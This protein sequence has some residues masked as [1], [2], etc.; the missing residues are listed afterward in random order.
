MGIAS[1]VIGIVAAILGFIPYCNFFAIIPAIVG[2]V[3]GIVDVAKKSKLNVPKGM[4]VAGI[5]LN[6][7]AIVIILLWVFII[8]AFTAATLSS[9][10]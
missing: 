3:L 5:V 2:L 9:L 6:S 1:M 8:G 10:Q 4:G 7:V